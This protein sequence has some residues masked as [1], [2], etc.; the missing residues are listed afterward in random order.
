MLLQV[1]SDDEATYECHVKKLAIHLI[2]QGK[3]NFV[4]D[5]HQHIVVTIFTLFSSDNESYGCVDIHPLLFN[6]CLMFRN[7]QIGY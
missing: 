2:V 1:S 5:G 6:V 7:D 4:N 3:L